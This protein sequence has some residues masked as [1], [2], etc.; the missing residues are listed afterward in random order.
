MPTKRGFARDWSCVVWTSPVR[1]SWHT[2]FNSGRTKLSTSVAI[3]WRTPLL[4]NRMNPEVRYI[5]L[6]TGSSY[7]QIPQM[8]PLAAETWVT[9][10][11]KSRVDVR[12]GPELNF[13]QFNFLKKVQHTHT[14]RLLIVLFFIFFSVNS[15]FRS[16]FF[17]FFYL[18]DFVSA[19]SLLVV[20]Q[21]ILPPKASATLTA[22]K[23]FRS[24]VRLLVT[25]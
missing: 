12:C 15:F 7:T 3:P 20:R 25:R 2:N 22:Q 23:W 10:P 13:Q 11:F 24:V 6:C 14:H 4:L 5:P 18:S 17:Y 9:N 16:F 19:A 8:F 1:K 21:A